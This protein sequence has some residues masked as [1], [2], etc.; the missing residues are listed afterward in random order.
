MQQT[1]LSPGPIARLSVQKHGAMEA[2][3]KAAEQASAA[4][5]PAEGGWMNRALSSIGLMQANGS[6]S[7]LRAA[8]AAAMIASHTFL[9]KAAAEEM[10]RAAAAEKAV[11]EARREA[12]GLAAEAAEAAE[13][14][15]LQRVRRDAE[16]QAEQ[17]RAVRPPSA[18]AGMEAVL[19]AAAAKLAGG[20]T[21]EDAEE[22]SLGFGEFEGAPCAI[23]ADANLSPK[24]LAGPAEEPCSV[25]SPAP[26]VSVGIAAQAE[27]PVA[28]A[29]ETV[30]IEDEPM[31]EL[32]V[33]KETPVAEE[34]AV[35]EEEADFDAGVEAGA[36][37][38]AAEQTKQEATDPTG[39]VAQAL[40]VEE[41]AME[42]ATGIAEGAQ[43]KGVTAV[44]ETP[45]QE[46]GA[47]AAT[48]PSAFA[49]RESFDE[50]AAV[51]AAADLKKVVWSD[52]D[53]G[54]GSDDDG[55]GD[56]DGD[57]EGEAA[58]RPAMKVATN[59]Q[60]RVHWIDAACTAVHAP[61][62]PRQCLCMYYFRW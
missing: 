48:P 7:D 17:L 25:Q 61:T 60:W 55:D 21:A 51:A 10:A 26:N 35:T 62:P 59:R 14:E 5:L 53:G 11:E 45:L 13:Q 22:D 16:Q 24:A 42:I 15:V 46:G 30:V 52:D 6:E 2:S 4:A 1:P 37:E 3:R 49:A 9:E 41:T 40:A 19:S 38:K 27:A 54:D 44:V 47:C 29:A 36:D 58:F 57:G 50:A 32:A 33:A 31:A 39:P 18:T 23:V 20:S 43:A 12:E 56:G 34:E 8:Q 28:A